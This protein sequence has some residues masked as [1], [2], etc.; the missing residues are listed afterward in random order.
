LPGNKNTHAENNRTSL[1][2]VPENKLLTPDPEILIKRLIGGAALL[3]FTSSLAPG[4]GSI[5]HG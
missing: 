4:F 5:A 3:G 2:V 1:S